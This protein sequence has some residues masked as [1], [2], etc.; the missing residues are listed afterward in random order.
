MHTKVPLHQA[1]LVVDQA[2]RPNP[3]LDGEASRFTAEYF[4]PAQFVAVHWRHGDYVAYKLL[5]P[6]E[7]LIERVHQ[8]LRGLKCRVGDE[9]DA[10]ALT[11]CKVFLMTN[12]RNASA[13]AEF[14]AAMEPAGGVVRYEP[15][16]PFHATEGGRLVI[17]QSI[18]A[19]ADAFVPSQRSAVSEF[20]ETLRR[21][22][23]RASK[24]SAKDEI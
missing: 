21:Q 12:C 24:P 18:A 1:R 13:L 11:P 16:Q 15:T 20:I 8:A 2:L 23:K 10:A 4:A 22:R 9:A 3:S 14:S 7:K 6:L 17:E 19:R 5:M